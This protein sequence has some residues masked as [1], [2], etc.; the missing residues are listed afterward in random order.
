M[1]TLGRVLLAFSLLGASAIGLEAPRRLSG[2]GPEVVNL[3]TA[4]EFA[5]L[6]KTGVTTTGTTSVT[7]DIG[8]SPIAA[9]ALT[10]FGLI[11][12]SSSTFS[13]SSLVTGKLFAASYTPPTP[14]KMT[15]AIGDMQTAYTDA[16]DRVGPRRQA[17]DRHHHE[18]DGA[19]ARAA[20]TYRAQEQG[21]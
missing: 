8:T 6:T 1:L 20:L 17:A 11:L 19:C 15:T 14:V 10:G 13:T 5:I 12:D 7:G 2:S 4:G 21:S 9:T 18:H 16:A 3:G